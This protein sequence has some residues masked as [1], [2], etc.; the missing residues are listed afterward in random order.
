MSQAFDI[1]VV[2]D[3]AQ[4]CALRLS[5]AARRGG[6]IAITGGSTPRAAY[7]RLATMELDWR[8]AALWF[9]DERC[10]PPDHEHSNFAMAHKALLGP[11]G[12][13]GPAV[14]RMRGEDGAERGAQAYAAELK[15]IQGE[16]FPSL[17]LIVL[18]MGA[19]AHVASLFPGRPEIDEQEATVVPVEMSGLPPFV[20]RISLSLPLINAAREIVFLVTGTEKAGAVARSMAGEASAPAARVAPQA[21]AVTW[22]L[23]RAAAS[24]IDDTPVRA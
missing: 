18:G 1:Q 23:D 15:E 8:G 21:G 10:V 4:E 6:Q 19:D 13:R 12:A 11:L 16:G 22:I 2:G 14:H 5:S 3:P 20:P 7:E 24:L 9:T 17:D